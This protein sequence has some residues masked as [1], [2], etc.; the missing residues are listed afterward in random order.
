M[1]L[2][3]SKREERLPERAPEQESSK[4]QEE[5]QEGISWL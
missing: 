2:D 1:H 3:M 5:E 4:V